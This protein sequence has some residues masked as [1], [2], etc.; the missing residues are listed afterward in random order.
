MTW[1]MYT[2]VIIGIFGTGY[3]I[4][5][6]FGKRSLLIDMIADKVITS[7]EFTRYHENL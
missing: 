2:L 6:Y 5:S 4:G 1:W 7:E 3:K